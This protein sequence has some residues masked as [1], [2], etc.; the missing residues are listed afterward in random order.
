M[1]FFF[2]QDLASA[3][4]ET[5]PP[6]V[7]QTCRTSHPVLWLIVSHAMHLFNKHNAQIEASWSNPFLDLLVNA[8]RICILA[9]LHASKHRN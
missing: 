3:P 5:L 4:L 6:I 8:N 2:S 1:K 7:K 9:S